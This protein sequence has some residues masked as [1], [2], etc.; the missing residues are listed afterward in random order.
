MLAGFLLLLASAPQ[1]S[2]QVTAPPASG[3][4]CA[5]RAKRV[6]VR[7]GEE[8][9]D[10][11]IL[12][13]R[14]LVVAVGPDVVVPEGV[15]VID[16]AVACAGFVDPWSSLGLDPESALDGGTKP[17]TR[18][19]DALDPWHLPEERAEALRAGVT[20]AR[21][22]AGRNA[23]LAGIG[24]VVHVEGG[25]EG[26]APVLL[27]DACLAASVGVAR[28]ERSPDVFDRIGE[29]DRLIAALEKARRHRESQ[30]EFRVELE[31]WSKAIAE[32]LVELEKDFK[33][34]KKD[35]EKDQKA[36]EEKDK[37]FKEKKYKEDKK[38]RKPRVDRDD[39]VVARAIDGELPLVVEVHRASEIRRLLEKT[40]DFDRLRLV[41]A[42]GT[43]ALGFAEELVEREIPVIVWP[44][45]LGAGRGDEY[46]AHDPAL[47][48][49]LDRAGVRVLIGSG[50]RRDARELRFL[51]ALAVGH[52]M[53]RE[54]ALAAI[55]T[56]PAQ[57]FD[58][59]RELGT[60]AP[61]R[62]ADVLVFD[63][64][65]LDTSAALRFVI[66]RGEVVV[67]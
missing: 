32:K 52:G 36:A 3:P 14:G 50:G 62:S 9:E 13:E 38:P 60:L 15:R 59:G 44:A 56:A 21:V 35:R 37:E 49:E 66:A 55:T 45:P 34:A 47:A 19:V 64:D 6:I 22:L 23:P 27:A 4:T 7:P 40:R 18:T 24:A 25:Q 58:S 29:V 57:V 65:P 42:G 39:D 1:P 33:K 41:I 26:E 51:A 48:G 31:K 54:A 53:E 8:L 10:A 46:E 17:A 11:I 43:E 63:G 28:G 61:G 2:T 67:Q 20:A 12:V 16:G 30:L 5:I